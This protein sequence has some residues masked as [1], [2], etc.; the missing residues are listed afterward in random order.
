M[1]GYD[2]TENRFGFFSLSNIIPNIILTI[3]ACSFMHEAIL[4]AT[5]PFKYYIFPTKIE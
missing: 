3:P 1:L 2:Q 4:R 5:I